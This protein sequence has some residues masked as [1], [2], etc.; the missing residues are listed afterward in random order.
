[1][2]DANNSETLNKLRAAVMDR[3]NVGNR[4]P[5]SL[6]QAARQVGISAATL[7]RFECGGDVDRATFEALVRWVGGEIRIDPVAAEGKTHNG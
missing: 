6:R 3:R 4:R 5:T 7:S 1:M 2:A